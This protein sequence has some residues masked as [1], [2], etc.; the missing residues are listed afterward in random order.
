MTEPRHP[1][2]LELDRVAL[3]APAAP[4]TRAHL[5]GCERCRAH[6]ARAREAGPV[7]A[8]AL[9]LGDRPRRAWW[10]GPRLAIAGGL[11][12]AAAA[13]L[14]VVVVGEQRA[15]VAR[16]PE[17]ATA[18]PAIAAKGSPE[19]VVHLKRGEVVSTWDGVSPVRPGDL[20]RLEVV[21]GENRHVQVLTRD[22]GP[23]GRLLVLY[24]AAL[25]PRAGAVALPFALEVDGAP[26]PE[27]VIVV[28][29]RAPLEPG[30]LA[31]GTEQVPAAGGWRTTI[32]LPKHT[33]GNFEP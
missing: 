23:A 30:A 18:G 4:A 10:S 3:G 32:V 29:S 16:A 12:A 17:T 5:E 26:G 15:R 28:L 14:L 19:V 21:P 7:P 8:W 1:S 20:L 2:F 33:E 24:S 9:Q 31:N 22:G 6:L 27:T 13:L 11:V 25:E